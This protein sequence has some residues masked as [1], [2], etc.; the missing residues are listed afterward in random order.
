MLD[1]SEE[2]RRGRESY[3][4]RAWRDAYESLS[5]ADQSAPLGAED[6]ELLATSAYMLG[7]D[8]DLSALERAHHLHLDAGETLRA[9]RCALWVGMHLSVRREMGRATGWL[10]RAQRLV[11]RE[12]RDCVEQGYL[13]FPTMFQHEAAGDYEAA[14][15]TAADAAEIGERFGDADLFALAVQAQGILLVQLGRVVEGLGLLDEAMVAVT[16]GELSPIV[17]GMVYCG[18]IKGCQDAYELRRAREWTAALTQWCEQQPDMVSF[19]GTCLVH[20]AEIMQLHGAWRDALE[21]A[22]LAGERC[23]QAMNRTAAAQ[24]FYRQGEVH[25][26]QGE[27]A[28]AEEAYREASRGGCEPQP[29]LALLRLAQGKGDAAAAAIRRV[30]GERTEPVE[31]ARLLP[32]YVEIMLDVGDVEEARGA[33][34]ELGEISAVY[35]SSMLDAM[36]AHARGAVDLAQGDARG[37]LLALRHAWQVWQELE[38]PYEAARVRVLLGLA[39]RTLGDDDT[40]AMELDAARGVFAQLGAA[41]DLA[42]V[43]SLARSAASADAHGLTARELQ[44]LRLVAAGKTNKAIA[45]ELV[46][47]ERTVDRHVSNIFTKLGVSSRAAATAYAYEHQL[48]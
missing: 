39:C 48:V 3:A 46:L 27:F 37:A 4:R 36:F 6:L 34:R 30:V 21:E 47:S 14:A 1:A 29:G 32:A 9:A 20:R 16:A 11:Q 7:R 41:P 43:D 24:A 26:L 33:C 10:G 40:A 25:R 17:S 2:L 15:A 23:A 38:V 42:R 44:V 13:L 31:R 18:V 22:Q 28:A 19:T 45:V 5:R 8:D 35:G 12:E